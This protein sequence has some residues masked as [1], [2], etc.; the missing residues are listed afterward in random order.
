MPAWTS[1]RT[2]Q[3]RPVPPR[4]RITRSQPKPQRLRAAW[5]GTPGHESEKS[6]SRPGQLAADAK[7]LTSAGNSEDIPA[8]LAAFKAVGADAG[9]LEQDPMPACADPARYWEQYLAD[10]KAAGDSHRPR[11]PAV[12]EG[13]MKNAVSVQNKLTTELTR[14]AGVKSTP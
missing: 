3:L 12:A 5:V 6:Q 10:L 4:R 2:E 7:K 1:C 11:W 9:Q 8:A 14:T 13:P